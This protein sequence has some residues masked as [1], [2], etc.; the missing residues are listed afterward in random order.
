MGTTAMPEAD[1]IVRHPAVA[2]DPAIA[3]IDDA[4]DPALQ[5]KVYDALRTGN[6][7]FG[8]KSDAKTDQ[9]SFWHRHFAGNLNPDHVKQDGKGEQYDCADELKRQSS[10]MHDVWQHLQDTALHD[11][12][13]VR[14]YAN[15]FPFGCEG[16]IHTDSIAPNSYTSVYYPHDEWHPN[17]GGETVFFN[18]GKTDIIA[19]VYPKPNRLVLFPG[20]VPHVARGL[21]RS[22]SKMRITLMFKTERRS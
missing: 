15:A 1:T 14:C 21:S 9:F 3:T 8:W 5:Q 16:T 22:C 11:H 19:A 20:T 6:W 7:K 10:L 4:L 2:R 18:R 13:L 12:R 17:W